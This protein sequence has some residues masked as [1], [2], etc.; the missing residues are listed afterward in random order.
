MKNCMF[1]EFDKNSTTEAKTAGGIVLPDE[2]RTKIVTVSIV[3]ENEVGI[4]AGDR[5][6]LN[7]NVTFT[8]FR[9][10]AQWYKQTGVS[11]VVAKIED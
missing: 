5:V 10:G 6:L 9:I 3:G 7:P 8:E 11:M 2:E 1:I 4:K